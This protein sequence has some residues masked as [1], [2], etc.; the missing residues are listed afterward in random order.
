[1]LHP[2]GLMSLCIIYP[3]HDPLIALENHLYHPLTESG[4]FLLSV[5]ILQKQRLTSFISSCQLLCDAHIKAVPIAPTG[6]ER[7]IYLI[8]PKSPCVR[9]G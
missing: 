9:A 5:L 7:S 3:A 1:M 2:S 4:A 6:A 8:P